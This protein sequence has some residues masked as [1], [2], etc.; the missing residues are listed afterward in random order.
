MSD[1]R[2]HLTLLA[3]IL[4]A[5]AGVA[6]LAVPGSPAHQKATLGLDLEGGLEVVLQAVPPKGQQVT[7]QG[8]SQALSIM[9]NRVDKLGVSD[10][11]ELAL[12][13]IHKGLHLVDR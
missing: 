12:Y 2:R 11:L 3:V 4:A 10:R 8:M 1:R 13:A 6:V 9:R 7:P 5:L